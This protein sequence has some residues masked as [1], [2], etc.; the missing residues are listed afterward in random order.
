M[1]VTFELSKT[2]RRGVIVT[3]FICSF[4]TTTVVAA[5]P[6]SVFGVGYSRSTGLPGEMYR[7]SESGTMTQKRDILESR[8]AIAIATF[9]TNLYVAG[10]RGA[11]NRY[12]F[13]GVFLGQFA[14]VR[15]MAGPS[16]NVPILET[17][18]T[19]DVYIAYSGQSS[20]PRTSFQ[21]T[22][23]GNI[24]KAFSHPNLVFP[25][26]IDATA[27]GRV[28]IV[29]SAG[30]G[31]RDRLFRFDSGGGYVADYA[32][33]ETDHPADIAINEISNELYVA[34][35]F[36]EAIVIY[37]ISLGAPVFRDSLSMPGRTVDVFVEPN[38]GRIFGT[39][40]V[41]EE[42]ERGL[43]SR[44]AGFEVSRDGNLITLFVEDAITREQSVR[45][46]VAVPVPEPTSALLL[47]LAAVVGS[48]CSTHR[49]KLAIYSAQPGLS[50]TGFSANE[51]D[52][53]Q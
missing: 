1:L 18:S 8:Q 12:D 9:G 53:L 36:G 41:F 29:N 16:P 4:S 39:Y 33:P 24:S 2:L 46:I 38:S 40:Y 47:L 37:D 15:G 30:I 25:V 50:V 43:H 13:N 21:L 6:V 35:E 34:D 49:R 45:G 17:D 14:D 28:Y 3:A 32:I 26:G 51:L 11:I 52:K 10:F 23:N 31:V 44:Y 19:G 7:F 27:D 20:Q 42:D 5:A 22:N 48:W